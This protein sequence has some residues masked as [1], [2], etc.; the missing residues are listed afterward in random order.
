MFVWL[1]FVVSISM[2]V[3][4][5]SHH[6]K[7]FRHLSALVSRRGREEDRDRNKDGNG[8]RDRDREP[9]LGMSENY[10]PFWV[11][12]IETAYFQMYL[13]TEQ[14]SARFSVAMVCD[15]SCHAAFS[16]ALKG[17]LPLCLSLF[18]C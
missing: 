10:D 16:L 18:R 13:A 5:C 7:Q 17:C 2:L 1:P 6:T 9:I 14:T 8:D 3:T 12:S 11:N 15:C 4:E